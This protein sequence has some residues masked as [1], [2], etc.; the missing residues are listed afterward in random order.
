MTKHS[1]LRVC[2]CA[3][4]D[5]FSDTN[6]STYAVPDSYAGELPLVDGRA[7]RLPG[8]TGP[9]VAATS[10]KPGYGGGGAGAG[11]AAA[12]SSASPPPLP[13]PA[14]PRDIYSAQTAGAL[15]LQVLC[16]PRWLG[17]R[18]VSVLDSGA[19]GPGFKSQPRLCRVTVLGKLFTPVSRASVHRA[20]KLVAALF[21]VAGVTAGL[22]ESNGSLP[23]GL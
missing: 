8:V 7:G 2:W 9:C 12:V 22:A 18:V 1:R 5:Y 14:H 3:Y 13:P 20:A 16:R 17:S 10:F 4:A 6:T 23:P 11:T 19:E 21:R 15:A